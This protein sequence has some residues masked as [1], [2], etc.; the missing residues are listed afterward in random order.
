MKEDGVRVAATLDDR[1]SYLNAKH[2]TEMLETPV[3]IFRMTADQ[4]LQ[5]VADGSVDFAVADAAKLGE[6]LPEELV[7]SACL[8]RRPA[9]EMMVFRTVSALDDLPVRAHVGTYRAASATQMK[10]WRA[11]VM[12]DV[13]AGRTEDCLDRFAEGDFDAFILP[14]ADC[15][16]LALKGI[17]RHEVLP[18]P[19]FTGPAGAGI[20][21]IVGREGMCLPRIFGTLHD[22]DTYRAY[23]AEM[24]FCRAVGDA[25]A[26][27]SV[28]AWQG[29]AALQI[30]AQVSDAAGRFH[31]DCSVSGPKPGEAGR[32]LYERLLKM[33]AGKH[34][35][36]P[37]RSDGKDN[38]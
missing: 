15:L 26:L 7:V 1:A 29:E 34:V 22:E 14:E 23:L 11:D 17:M 6:P 12:V 36:W 35:F 5:K 16:R 33:G 25:D 18:G 31:Y 9:G 3:E 20:T 4:L 21:L 24:A 38:V 13:I 19:V 28:Y 10:R 2:V 27:Y 30:M 32:R 8:K 37:V